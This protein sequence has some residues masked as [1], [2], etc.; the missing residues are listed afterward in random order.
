MTGIGENEFKKYLCQ[1]V[2]ARSLETL[3]FVRGGW[4][5]WIQVDLAAFLLKKDALMDVVREQFVFTY[6]RWRCDL[7]F[8]GNRGIA[9][10]YGIVEIKA[11]SVGNG[12]TT[13]AGMQADLAKVMLHLGA[14][15]RDGWQAVVG[16][17]IDQATHE[18]LDATRWEGR[19]AFGEL[20]EKDGVA[21]VGCHIRRGTIYPFTRNGEV[22]VTWSLDAEPAMV[23]PGTAG[24][25]AVASDGGPS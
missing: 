8:N 9:G 1:W 19:K 24:R 12:A 15:Y 22:P 6:P 3:P 20:I 23:D 10:N 21:V 13:V 17:V 4:E 11:Q 7:L 5:D 16:F 14:A 18:A 2:E 25:T